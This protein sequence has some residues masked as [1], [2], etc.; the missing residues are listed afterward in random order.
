MAMNAR[1]DAPDVD[2]SLDDR[3]T[4]VD[5]PDVCRLLSAE[6]GLAALI[7]EAAEQLVRF[8]PDAVLRLEPVVDP[9]YEGDHEEL[10]LSADTS[11]QPLDA[12]AAL[13]RFDDTWWIPNVRRARGRF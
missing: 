10:L 6:P 1:S 11:L 5:E 7:N 8:I 4:V 13:R 9:E 2:V 12:L 3:I